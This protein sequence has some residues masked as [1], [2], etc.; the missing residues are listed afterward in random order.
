LNRC[1]AD[2]FF[3]ATAV[4]KSDIREMSADVSQWPYS[5]QTTVTLAELAVGSTIVACM[6]ILVCHRR[7]TTSRHRQSDAF[8][9]V[10]YVYCITTELERKDSRRENASSN[11]LHL[12]HIH[13]QP[14]QLHHSGSSGRGSA[15]QKDSD[16]RS[17]PRSRVSGERR[18][19]RRHR[20]NDKRTSSSLNSSS[21][22]SSSSP[23]RAKWP[24][25]KSDSAEVEDIGRIGYPGVIGRPEAIHT[26]EVADGG[27]EVAPVTRET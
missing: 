21:L 9:R 4:N 23:T 17:M 5:W 15:S 22:S 19:N 3:S 8:K 18:E 20:N 12:S 25:G 26:T 16:N 10:D 2:I 6:V 1:T 14:Q 27:R 13:R 7:R 11:S 24:D